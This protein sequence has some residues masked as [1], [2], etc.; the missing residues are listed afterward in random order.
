MRFTRKKKRTSKTISVTLGTIIDSNV[1]ELPTSTLN[2][3]IQEKHNI[4]H[5]VQEQVEYVIPPRDIV[6][7]IHGYLDDIPLP[8]PE[9][10]FEDLKISVEDWMKFFYSDKS[11]ITL[12]KY[13]ED[14]A[15]LVEKLGPDTVK[16]IKTGTVAFRLLKRK[17]VLFYV[18]RRKQVVLE[19]HRTPH[20]LFM[21]RC[22]K[23]A[24]LPFHP[25]EPLPQ[26]FERL[27]TFKPAGLEHSIRGFSQN[28]VE[29]LQS[30]FLPQLQAIATQSKAREVDNEMYVENF[31]STMKKLCDFVNDAGMDS[32]WIDIDDFM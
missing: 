8:F 4:L 28:I 13:I 1:H 17:L 27:R 7:L 12:E 24:L 31:S 25:P 14:F 21:L 32:K 30:L 3:L 10:F 16:N 19:I 9:T 2:C 26:I 15:S 6:F 22:D 23:E 29:T 18:D 11:D 5:R 20:N